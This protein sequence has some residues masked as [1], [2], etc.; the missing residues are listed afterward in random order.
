MSGSFWLGEGVMNRGFRSLLIRLVL[1]GGLWLWNVGPFVL[2][3][4][5]EGIQPGSDAAV[6]SGGP[7][8]AAV[9]SGFGWLG[10]QARFIR[11]HNTFWNWIS[12]LLGLAAGV[13]A[14]RV[15][16]GLLGQVAGRFQ[17]RGW[18]VQHQAVRG[19]VGP[20][21]L[22]LISLGLSIGMANF[23]LG[24]LA[25]F[26]GKT[27]LLL[28]T[29]AVLWYASNLVALV[30]IGLRRL[31]AR[32]ESAIDEYLGPWIRRIL[33]AVLW[34]LGALFVVNSVFEQ[35]IG[36]WLAGLGIAG[37]AVSLAAQDSLKNFFGSLTI[38]MDRPFHVGERIVFS[39]YDG[40]IE[41]IGF[42]STKVRTLTGH[43]VTIPNASIVSEAIEN[44]GRRP[45]IRRVMNL[46]IT[47]DT[48]AEKVRQAVQIVRDILEEDDIRG[49]IHE[50]INGEPYPPRVYFNEYNPDS[51]NILVIYWYVPPS[52][53][54]YLEH[55][56]RINLRV[57][58]A[59]E[60]AG[61][62]FAYPTQ[63][64][65]LAGDPKRRLALELLGADPNRP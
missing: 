34:T 14:G 40:V 19:S 10:D 57:F 32:R 7:G 65:Y 54:D 43:M 39:G 5:S 59:F 11:Q 26:W 64:V 35:D 23:H 12:P 17:A 18:L 52:Y 55:A 15:L 44:I 49:P 50:R 47:Y 9:S 13:I 46:T 16:A 36:A 29:I 1:A 4:G 42:R 63:T 21:A 31:I 51:L 24:E 28:Y 48:P 33:R 41:E 3:A 20:A 38:L 2:A 61:I 8:Q 56:Q 37:L 45:S 22:G 62:E 60:E 30:D 25:A 53:W 6:P 27:V 58:E